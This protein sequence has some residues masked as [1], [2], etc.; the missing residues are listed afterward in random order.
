MRG[1]AMAK[2]IPCLW[3]DGNAEEAATFYRSVFERSRIVRTSHYGEEGREITGGKPG[4]VLTIELELEGLTLTLLNGGPQ[5]KFSEAV[6]IQVMC[7]TQE[8]IDRY[9][10]KLSAV[11]HAEQ[12]GWVK[13]KL[14]F[15]WQLV[16]TILPTLIGDPDPKKAGRVMKA[17]LQMKRL[18]IAALKKAHAG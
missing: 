9:A 11:P 5:F 8:E 4:S 2:M 18:D 7:E 6:S 14:G 13:D 16:P 12:C 17:M 3:F 15:S 1:E 10:S